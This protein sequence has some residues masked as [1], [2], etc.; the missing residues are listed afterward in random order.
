MS[1]TLEHLEW[2]INTIRDKLMFGM[3]EL[4]AARSRESRAKG[5]MLEAK[6]EIVRLR[7]ALLYA[8]ENSYDICWQDTEHMPLIKELK[9]V[10]NI[11]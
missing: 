8:Y 10:K 6:K 3:D 2:A 9:D 1:D 4:G 5:A 7:A 11:Q